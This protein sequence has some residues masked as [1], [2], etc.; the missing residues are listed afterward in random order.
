MSAAE[1]EKSPSVISSRPFKVESHREEGQKG[2]KPGREKVRIRIGP[3]SKAG[4]DSS[5][6]Q[7]LDDPLSD[8]L[9]FKNQ[10]ML[11]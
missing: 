7:V 8:C 9:S 11:G 6:T 1:L 10:S 5:R 3:S 2:S 4:L